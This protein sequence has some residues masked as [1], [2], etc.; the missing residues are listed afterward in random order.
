MLPCKP[1]AAFD[2]LFEYAERINRLNGGTACAIY[3]I[4]RGRIVAEHYSGHHSHAADAR[5][6]A[7]D[8]QFHVASVRKS[9]IGFA[10][11]WAVHSGGIA[12][13]DEPVS[14][15][16][17][18]D[19]DSRRLL[20]GV[21]VRHLLTHTHGLDRDG[22]GRLVI[23]FAPGT[24]W[25]YNNTGIQLLTELVPRVTGLTVAEL[26]EEKI[27][28]PL[29]WRETGWRTA[30][31]ETLVPVIM[32]QKGTAKLLVHPDPSGAE[33]NL[34]VSA[35]ELAWWGY[36][37]LK[38]GQLNGKQIAPEAVFRLSVSCQS[39]SS[40]PPGLPQNGCLWFVNS[41]PSPQYI[42]GDS[43]PRGSYK[44]VG[45]SGPLLLVVPELDLV[46][47]RMANKNG[48]YEDEQGTYL[49]YLKAF[50]DRAVAAAKRA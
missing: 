3:V 8:S 39:P 33:P 30:P 49:D 46:L 12:S 6:A 50:S 42:I 29:G 28:A 14:R 25:A 7:A 36:L 22:D 19:E 5:P 32:D 47:V 4:Q 31:A 34:H 1:T 45:H 48:N 26:L 10:V 9:Y 13:L 11:A 2:S 43:V 38:A 16:L 20:D 35:R 23:R 40:L 21:A 17:S 27:F 24:G 37:H 18:T 15:Y 41:G 44:I